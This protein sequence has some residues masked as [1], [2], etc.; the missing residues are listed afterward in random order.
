MDFV[1]SLGFCTAWLLACLL[2]LWASWSL[3]SGL[4]AMGTNTP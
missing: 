4:I 1:T 3:I 2:P